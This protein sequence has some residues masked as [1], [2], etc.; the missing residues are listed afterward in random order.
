MKGVVNCDESA[1]RLSKMKNQ[2]LHLGLRNIDIIGDFGKYSLCEVLQGK[3]KKKK[4]KCNGL[5]NKLGNI[6]TKYG[7]SFQEVGC[8]GKERE[9]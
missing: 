1:N 9:E 6:D 7:Q 5:K 4:P 3:G 8:E 2:N